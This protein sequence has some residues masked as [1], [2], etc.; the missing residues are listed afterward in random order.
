MVILSYQTHLGISECGFNNG[1]CSQ[2]CSNSSGSFVCSCRD[3]FV[4]LSDSYSCQGKIIT[5]LIADACVIY[6]I[7]IIIIIIIKI[8]II[9]IIMNTHGRFAIAFLPLTTR[10]STELFEAVFITKSSG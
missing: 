2:I 7:I 5:N 1:G 9:I 8:I 6:K 4:L 3:G 10:L